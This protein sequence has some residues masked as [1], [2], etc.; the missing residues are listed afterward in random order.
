MSSS[1]AE[2]LFVSKERGAEMSSRLMPP[3][4][5]AIG[6][7]SS[8]ISSASFVARHDRPGVDSLD[9]LEQDRLS[10]HD[11]QCGRRPDVS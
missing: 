8:T 11:G 3:K 7:R 2:R 10:L 1:F 4:T 9:F 5:G 6:T